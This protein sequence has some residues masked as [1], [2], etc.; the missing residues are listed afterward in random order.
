M[1]PVVKT[2]RFRPRPCQGFEILGRTLDDEELGPALSTTGSLHPG[3]AA[4]AD[5]QAKLSGRHWFY[6]HFIVFLIGS[7]NLV[8]VNAARTPDIWWAWMPIVAWTVV[9]AGHVLWLLV[10]KPG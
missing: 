10:K 3:G 4:P 6:A 1:Q 8:A 2:R 5:A 9:L 7:W